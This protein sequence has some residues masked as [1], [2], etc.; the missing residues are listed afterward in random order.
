MKKIVW[1]G[2]FV[3]IAVVATAF[4]VIRHREQISPMTRPAGI[5]DADWNDLMSWKGTRECKTMRDELMKIMSSAEASGGTTA[6]EAGVLINYMHSPHLQARRTAAIVAGYVRSEPARSVLVSYVLDLLSDPV[7]VV[8][9]RAAESIGK[10]GD[11]SVIPSLKPLLK[12]PIPLVTSAAQ[13][14]ISRL[15]SQKE[16]VPGK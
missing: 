8:R 6:D 14:A 16:A 13:E 2:V 5:P 4:L 1:L 12:D 10:M 11:K 15:Q 3:S 9:L 7:S